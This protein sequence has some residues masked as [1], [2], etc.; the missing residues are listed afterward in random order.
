MAKKAKKQS[1]NPQTKLPPKLP[2]KPPPEWRLSQKFPEYYEVDDLP[3]PELTQFWSEENLGEYGRLIVQMRH[4]IAME[5]KEGR[6]L[7][8]EHVKDLFKAFR[9]S[10]GKLISANQAGMLA[11]FSRDVDEQEGGNKQRAKPSKG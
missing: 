1:N 3:K 6:C 10:N 4:H 2:L 8:H 9:L 5:A 7:K 11:T